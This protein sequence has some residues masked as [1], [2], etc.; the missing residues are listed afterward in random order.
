MSIEIRKKNIAKLAKKFPCKK[1]SNLALEVNIPK[2]LFKNWHMSAI[3]KSGAIAAPPK[4]DNKKKRLH[5]ISLE[6]SNHLPIKF[7]TV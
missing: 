7:T 2:Q 5:K 3:T 1:I 4:I 6:N